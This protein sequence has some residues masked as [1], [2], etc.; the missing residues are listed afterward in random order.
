MCGRGPAVSAVSVIAYDDD[1]GGSACRYTI[2]REPGPDPGRPAAARA[3]RRA[4]RRGRGLQPTGGPRR[5]V[6]ARNRVRLARDGELEF[7]G[8][9]DLQ[10]KLRGQ[11]I[12]LGEVE[13]AL[14]AQRCAVRT[15]PAIAATARPRPPPGK[16]QSSMTSQ[17]LP[18]S[19]VRALRARIAA[20]AVATRRARSSRR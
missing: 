4:V 12:E 6:P 14:R 5:G 3:D 2:R 15:M 17:R 8:R 18:N 10:V 13:H 7:G 16:S 1:D 20:T 11:R 9:I 19:Y